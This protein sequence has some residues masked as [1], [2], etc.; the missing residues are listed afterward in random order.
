MISK[1]YAEVLKEIRR[2]GGELSPDQE[3]AVTEI[4]ETLPQIPKV[5][6]Y[7]K[8]KLIYQY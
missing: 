1:I 2:L 6:D 5:I 3:F 4:E 8:R 7:G